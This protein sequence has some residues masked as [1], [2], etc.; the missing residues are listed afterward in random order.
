V[1]P[2]VLTEV[3]TAVTIIIAVLR[4]VTPCTLLLILRRC[5]DLVCIALS[6][7][8]IGAWQIRKETIVD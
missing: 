1:R 7:T 5:R 8:M 3:L 2:E 6:D 4:D